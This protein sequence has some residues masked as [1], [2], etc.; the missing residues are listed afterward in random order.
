M[1]CPRVVSDWINRKI[2]MS[3]VFRVESD[4][5]RHTYRIHT[6]VAV[7]DDDCFSTILSNDIARYYA[8]CRLGNPTELVIRR[9]VCCTNV[10]YV[11]YCNVVKIVTNAAIADA[12]FVGNA[13]VSYFQPDSRWHYSRAVPNSWTGMCAYYNTM[14]VCRGR[15]IP[16]ENVFYVVCTCVG[17]SLRWAFYREGMTKKKRKKTEPNTVDVQT[18]VEPAYTVAM[19]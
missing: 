1:S 17:L 5:Y 11:R 18:T 16:R 15:C 12:I 9:D 7:P 8:R 10:S 2:K 6:H 4:K 13:N 19:E 3:P 14:A